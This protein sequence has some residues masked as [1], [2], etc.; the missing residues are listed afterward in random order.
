MKWIFIMIASFMSASFTDQHNGWIERDAHMQ[1]DHNPK[2]EPTELFNSIKIINNSSLKHLPNVIRDLSIVLD[3]TQFASMNLSQNGFLI[4]LN[5]VENKRYNVSAFV[6]VNMEDTNYHVKLCTFNKR[7]SDKALA[8]T[9]IHEIMHCV[10]LNV[11]KRAVRKDSKAIAT[12][13]NFNVMLERGFPGQNH[14]FFYLMNIGEDGQHE[15]LYHIFYPQMVAIL[16]QFANI[17]RPRFL[18][19]SEAELLMWSG[20]QKTGA[21]GRLTTEERK[22]IETAILREKGFA[23]D[24]GD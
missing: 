3:K 22:D 18:D 21:Y 14:D 9:L 11:Y 19:Y 5:D 15:L 17:H 6:T 8:A 7:A 16:N 13:K 10:L 1:K 2:D 24:L 4:Y 20:L 23:T 12:I